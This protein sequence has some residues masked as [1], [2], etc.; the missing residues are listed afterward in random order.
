MLAS[1]P[2][3]AWLTPAAP[4]AAAAKAPR[5]KSRRPS[6]A[7]AAACRMPDASR[8]F[9]GALRTRPVVIGSESLYS[10]SQIYARTGG[11]RAGVFARRSS[12]VLLLLHQQVGVVGVHA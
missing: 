9:S 7:C 1:P 5:R 2:V 10:D 8:K 4:A 6:R 3:C 12:S 11:R